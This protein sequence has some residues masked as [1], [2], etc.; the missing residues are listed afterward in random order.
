MLFR[1][2]RHHV[3]KTREVSQRRQNENARSARTAMVSDRRAAP[4]RRHIKERQNHKR[5]ANAN[6]ERYYAPSYK[7]VLWIK[8]AS[9][10][11]QPCAMRYGATRRVPQDP[12]AVQHA[13]C[14]VAVHA[15]VGG[16]RQTRQPYARGGALNHM[17]AAS[18]SFWLPIR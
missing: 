9:A 12:T 17:F 15:F 4:K 14:Y 10:E 5:H 11:R 2:A 3:A 18:P 16:A 7:T 8:T 1:I 13:L 6:D